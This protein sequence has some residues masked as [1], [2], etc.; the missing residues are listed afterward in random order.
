[1]PKKPRATPPKACM[2]IMLTLWGGDFPFS[3]AVGFTVDVK[4]YPLFL[5]YKISCSMQL[6]TI[7]FHDIF[8]YIWSYVSFWCAS[9]ETLLIIYV[10]LNASNITKMVAV[11]FKVPEVPEKILEEKVPIAVPRKPEPPVAKG[12]LHTR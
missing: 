4:Y 1:M 3:W 8:F 5:V 7:F 11:S 12:M 9:C 6:Y 10:F 2:K